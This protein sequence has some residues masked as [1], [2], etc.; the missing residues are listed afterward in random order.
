M[1]IYDSAGTER[2]SFQQL[3]K[4]IESKFILQAGLTSLFLIVKPPSSS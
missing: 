4:L 2:N 3:P 1:V